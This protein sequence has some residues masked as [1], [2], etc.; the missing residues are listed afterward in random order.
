MVLEERRLLRE[1]FH[2]D[3]EA[4]FGKHPCTHVSDFD[5]YRDLC[6]RRWGDLSPDD[7]LERSLVFLADLIEFYIEAG[8]KSGEERARAVWARLEAICEKRRA[9][10]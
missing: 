8:S 10:K 7:R 4:V 6:R 5:A 9:G 2:A 1:G 3:V